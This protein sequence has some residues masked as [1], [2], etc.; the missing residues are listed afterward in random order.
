MRSLRPSKDWHGRPCK[1]G[2]DGPCFWTLFDVAV[3]CDLQHV[4]SIVS[5]WSWDLV[6][7]ISRTNAFCLAVQDQLKQEVLDMAKRVGMSGFNLLVIDTENKVRCS[8]AGTV[9]PDP[10]P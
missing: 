4:T 5:S 10:T 2:L 1:E 9:L 8:P 6:H 3:A 7:L